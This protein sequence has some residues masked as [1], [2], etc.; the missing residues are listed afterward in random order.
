MV[1][2]V[3]AL[4][5]IDPH[6]LL[7]DL[8]NY[9]L[10]GVKIRSKSLIR[11]VESDDLPGLRFHSVATLKYQFG[12]VLESVIGIEL[13]KSAFHLQGLQF[14]DVT[15]HAFGLLFI[16]PALTSFVD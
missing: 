10:V 6:N 14:S 12:Q 13:G 2:V 11:L 1:C 4:V 16:F 3:L 9:G 7:K 5:G 15:L 8:A